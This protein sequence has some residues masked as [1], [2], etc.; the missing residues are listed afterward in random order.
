MIFLRLK[1]RKGIVKAMV[2]TANTTNAD[3]FLLLE[4]A[5]KV[6]LENISDT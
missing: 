4:V 3:A 6:G 2:S 5:L 1:I